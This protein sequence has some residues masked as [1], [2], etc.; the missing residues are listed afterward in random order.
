MNDS[1]PD[2]CAQQATPRPRTKGRWGIAFAIGWSLLLVLILPFPVV[3]L[4]VRAAVTIVSLGA[5]YVL[6]RSLRGWHYLWATPLIL[7]WLVVNLTMWTCTPPYWS[8]QD[9]KRAVEERAQWNKHH[10]NEL[11]VG[12]GKGESGTNR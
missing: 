10:R 7:F 1:S 5:F 8:E 9:Y 11:P 2:K 4:E 3:P 6:L 12:K